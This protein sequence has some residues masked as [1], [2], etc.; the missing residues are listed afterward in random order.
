MTGSGTTRDATGFEAPSALLKMN[1]DLSDDST[2]TFAHSYTESP[3]TDVPYDAFDPL[4][5]GDLV[6]RYMK[7]HH[8]LPGL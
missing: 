2:L 7:G 4:W 8:H 6:D 3:E 1:F 5:S